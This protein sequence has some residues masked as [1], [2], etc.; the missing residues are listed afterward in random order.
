MVPVHSLTESG[1]ARGRGRPAS[2]LLAVSG[3]HPAR[4]RVPPCEWEGPRDPSVRLGLVLCKACPPIGSRSLWA[5]ALL[6][7][8]F[9]TVVLTICIHSSSSEPSP[10]PGGR[11]SSLAWGVR[12]GG[13]WQIRKQA[14]VTMVCIQRAEASRARAQRGHWSQ[15]RWPG[16]HLRGPEPSWCGRRG[17][18]RTRL[19]VCRLCPAPAS[20]P[21]SLSS[22]NNCLRFSKFIS[23]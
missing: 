8:T 20:L 22:R 21:F 11:R 5:Q 10:G 14:P 15:G 13:V 4:Q 9:P 3:G 23:R 16:K 12:S 2:C 18:A 17:S 1:L 19:S 6:P 7:L